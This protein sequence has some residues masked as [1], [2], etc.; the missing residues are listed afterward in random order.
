MSNVQPKKTKGAI[1]ALVIVAVLLIGAY[2]FLLGPG[3]KRFYPLEY[4]EYIVAYAQENDIDPYMVAAV[5]HT[6]SGF[7]ANAVSRSGAMGLMQIMP[8]TGEWIAG[9]FDMQDFSSDK[10][11]EPETNIKFGCWYLNFLEDTFDGD[12]TLVWAGYNAGQGR[13]KEWLADASLSGDGKTLDSIPY[14]ETD[15]YVK[16]VEKA[17]QK[18]KEFYEIG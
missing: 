10:L 15:K 2:Y 3:A 9:K 13:V 5:I 4:E 11:F 1:V 14:E 16:K 8:E 7:D 12:K 6:E 17:Y 18:Y